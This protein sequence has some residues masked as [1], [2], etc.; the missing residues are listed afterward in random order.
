MSAIF[1]ILLTKVISKFNCTNVLHMTI[2]QSVKLK[3]RAWQRVSKSEENQKINIYVCISLSLIHTYVE[4]SQSQW[5]SV[6]VKH[7]QRRFQ[8]V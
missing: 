5:S 7:S 3:Y 6:Q 1:T 4:K 8:C 2:T